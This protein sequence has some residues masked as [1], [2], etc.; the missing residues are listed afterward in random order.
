MLVLIVLSCYPVGQPSMYDACAENSLVAAIISQEG[1]DKEG[2]VIAI[3]HQCYQNWNS[4]TKEVK[5]KRTK[6][7]CVAAVM[8]ELWD[9]TKGEGRKSIE[10]RQREDLELKL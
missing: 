3:C 4:C 9:E 10:D 5:N 1:I 6:E 7:F 8:P 2:G